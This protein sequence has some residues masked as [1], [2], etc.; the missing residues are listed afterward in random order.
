MEIK[1]K[2]KVIWDS[3][4]FEILNEAAQAQ[5]Q[6]VDIQ[7]VQGRPDCN[8]GPDTAQCAGVIIRA[9]NARLAW[10]TSVMQQI[11]INKL[12]KLPTMS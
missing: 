8:A 3:F 10:D 4:H 11:V 7:A 6:N 1:K 2:A 5:V 12:I 9:H